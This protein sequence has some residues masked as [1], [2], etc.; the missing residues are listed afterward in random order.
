MIAITSGGN[1]GQYPDRSVWTTVHF[2][3]RLISEGTA[4]FAHRSRLLTARHLVGRLALRPESLERAK[5]E[6]K[7][8]WRTH[9]IHNSV[10]RVGAP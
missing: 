7:K 1:Y 9:E 5:R 4:L 8:S 10:R 2:F 6:T 3:T